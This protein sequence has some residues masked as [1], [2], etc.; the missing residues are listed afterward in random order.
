M[1]KDKIYTVME[2]NLHTGT[3]RSN[4]YNKEKNLHSKGQNLHIHISIRYH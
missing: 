2:I 1:V 4:L 3:N